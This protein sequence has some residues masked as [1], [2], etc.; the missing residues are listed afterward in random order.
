MK[1]IKSF[2]VF[3]SLLLVGCNT[4]TASVKEPPVING[5]SAQI[6]VFN[7]SGPTLFSQD[8]VVLD[9]GHGFVSIPRGKYQVAKMAT[10]FHEFSLTYRKKPVVQLNASEGQTFYMVVGYNPAK[11]WAFPL[12]GDPV[13]LKQIT[14]EEAKPLIEQFQPM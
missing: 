11:S 9:N 1:S 12:G 3:L 13:V 6:Y 4:N 10:G 5:P 2:V 14:Q 8:Q 7:I